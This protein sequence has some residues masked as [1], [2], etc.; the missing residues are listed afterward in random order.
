MNET[1]M[2][3]KDEMSS[4][5]EFFDRNLRDGFDWSI[6]QEYPLAMNEA[7]LNNFRI[8]KQGDQIVSGAVMKMHIIK[9]VMGLFK[10]AAIGSVVTS[11][12]HRNQG[13]SQKV[14]NDCIEASEQQVCDFA[15]L[16]SDLYD[17]YRKLG[18]ELAGTEVSMVI[19]S[20]MNSQDSSIRIMK[21][22]KV[23]A[24]ALLKVF[25]YH[26]TGTIRT[27]RVII[28]YLQIPNSNGY[29]AWDKNNQLLAYAVEGKGADLT[30]YIHEWGGMV[31]HLTTLFSHIRKEKQAPI[32][33]I[34]P[35]NAQNLIRTMK[36][37]D[38][39]VNYGFLGMIKILN[40]DNF[41]AKAC[42]YA[43]NLGVEGFVLHKE[44]KQFLIGY[45]DKIYQTEHETDITRIIFGPQ[46]EDALK[47]FDPETRK[48]L[49]QLFPVPFW[50]WGWDSV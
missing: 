31:T 18:F 7:N 33:I 22:N 12:E 37:F 25:N 39:T 23:S 9:C 24:E 36:Q 49:D 35:S 30:N 41:F 14:L 47:G 44:E 45:K 27:V 38:V 48:V 6:Q 4:T 8:I 15:I 19:N 29:T 21:S 1:T 42:R 50:F 20:E 46:S 43:R 13:F 2:P 5:L 16:W 32:T 17:F 3:T 26:T 40:Y 34:A 11:P 10:A 28:A